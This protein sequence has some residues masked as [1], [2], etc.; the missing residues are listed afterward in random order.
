MKKKTDINVLFLS[1]EL[2]PLAKVGGLGD[3]AGSLPKAISGLGADIRMFIPFYGCI[4]KKKYQAE[5]ILDF[6]FSID[7]RK[8]TVHIHKTFLPATDIPVY[9]IQHR[10]FSRKPVYFGLS[11][12]KK[13]SLNQEDYDIKRFS[14]YTKSSLEACIR[15][16]LL[17]IILPTRELQNRE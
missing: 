8:E 5:K 10:F 12:T 3:V 17:S 2:T 15:L 14:L 6:S 4:D 7:N 11:Q 16:D 9:L 1:A 13:K